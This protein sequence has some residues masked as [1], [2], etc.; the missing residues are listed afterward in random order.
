MSRFHLLLTLALLYCMIDLVVAKAQKRYDFE[1]A[2][3]K[4]QAVVGVGCRLRTEEEKEGEKAQAYF[5]RQEEK[6]KKK[7][8]EKANYKRQ[9]EEKA[10]QQKEQERRIKQAEKEKCPYAILGVDRDTSQTEVKQAYRALSLKYH[11]DKNPGCEL[12]KTKFS[13]LADAYEVLERKRKVREE[14]QQTEAEKKAKQQKEQERRTRRILKEEEERKQQEAEKKAKQRK[15]R[16]EQERLIHR[17]LKEDKARKQQEDKARHSG[18][19]EEEEE[20]CKTQEPQAIHNRGQEEEAKLRNEQAAANKR[21]MEEED[22]SKKQRAQA[23]HNK[24]QEEEKA[25]QQKEQERLIEQA[26]KEKCP[27]AVLGVDSDASQTEVKKAYRTLSLKYHPDKNPGCE[28]SKTKFTK[29]VDA[30]EILGDA[31]RR[32]LHDQQQFGAYESR[33]RDYDSKTGFYSGSS[34]VTSLNQTDFNRLVLCKGSG[35]NKEDCSPWMVKFYAPWCVHCKNMIQDWKRAASTMDGTE[36][37]LGFVQF[38]GVNC[39]TEK[40]LCTKLGVWGYPSVYLYAHDAMGHQHVELLSDQKARTVDNFIEFAERG[41]R[42]VHEATLQTIDTFLM[43]KNVTNSESTGLWIV[44]FEGNNCPECGSLKASL[45]RMSANIRGLA[46][47]GVLHCS[48]EQKICKDQYVKHDGYPVLKMYPYQ[49]SKG[50]GET[51]YQP[52]GADPLLILPVVE[53][54]IRMCIANIEAA[55]GLMKTLHDEAPE[56]PPPPQVEYAYPEPRRKVH[57]G[58]PAGTRAAA[59]GQYI[60]S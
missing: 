26:E 13:K 58:L 18:G 36:T 11:P 57:R 39:E 24:R 25:K 20:E 56:E 23:S 53:K 9:E 47:F 4:A 3:K 49:G 40:K 35:V 48:Q 16:K 22:V 2:H 34:M 17:I 33:P 21:K 50:T 37:P 6:K 54:V 7:Q 55:N 52:G 27:Y 38:G 59:G 29:L 42:L 43:N 31:D 32:V 5:K 8:E 41:T 14:M 28:L 12:S 46:N 30:Y 19:Q 44:L 15:Q 45:R 10:K 1:G 51:L 60:T